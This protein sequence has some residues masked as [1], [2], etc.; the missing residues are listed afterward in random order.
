ME[1]ERPRCDPLAHAPMLGRLR[2]HRQPVT[3]T[4]GHID[5][6]DLGSAGVGEV[7]VGDA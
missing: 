5:S 7:L 4:S 2:S 3:S 1:Q 6:R